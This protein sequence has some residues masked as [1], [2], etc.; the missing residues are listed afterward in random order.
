VKA[1]K[2]KPVKYFIGALFTSEENL[3]EAMKMLEQK[4]SKI[5]MESTNFLFDVTNYYDE[6]MGTPIYRKIFSFNELICPSFLPEA[7]LITNQVEEKLKVGT[8]RKVNLDIG[9]L[10][11][12]KVVLASAKYCLNKVYLNKGIYADLALH[13]Q[14]GKYF[15]YPWAFMDFKSDRYYDFF[16]KIR[17]CYKKQVKLMY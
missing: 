9:Y 3:Q 15:P 10:D 7:K 2:A 17:M 13:Y 6:E 14:K 12:D 11:Y 1:E 16:F 8:K 5:D 4:F